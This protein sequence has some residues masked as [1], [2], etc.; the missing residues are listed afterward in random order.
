MRVKLAAA[1]LVLEGLV[2]E[3]FTLVRKGA[4]QLR[5][6][7]EADQWRASND[8]LYR[9]Y[10]REF[11][12][13]VHELDQAAQDKNLDRAALAWVDTTLNCVECHKWVNAM[14]IAD[15]S[16]LPGAG[17]HAD[18]GRVSEAL[19]V[20]HRSGELAIALA[21]MTTTA[22]PQDEPVD[23]RNSPDR[24]RPRP[25]APEPA[26]DERGAE[27]RVA[28]FMREKLDSAQKVLEGVLVEDFELVK[29]G[30]RRMSI[31]SQ[32]AEWHVFATP[33]YGEDST[34]FRTKCRQ[35]LKAADNQRTDAAA[36]SYLQLTLSCVRCHQHVRQN[37]VAATG[38]S[39]RRAHFAGVERQVH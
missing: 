31:M 18:L 28:R 36:L 29:K 4:E 8:V 39:S 22:V 10:S 3:E 30:A 27:Q 26:D 13:K 24:P 7:S 34:E 15:R 37:R 14:L 38:R 19:L 1:D 9:Q 11:Q 5:R 35:L 2:T 32:A 23:D 33:T 12:R 17:P 25:V 16:P 20:Q 21:A 6:T